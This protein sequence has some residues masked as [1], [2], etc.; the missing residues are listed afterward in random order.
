MLVDLPPARTVRFQILARISFDLW[1]A[2]LTA[3]D[4]IPVGFQTACQLRLIDGRSV[5]LSFVKLSRLERTGLAL[6]RLR[7]IEDDAMRMQLRGGV[8]IY[9]TGT[10]VFEFG[11]HPFTRCFRS[12]IASH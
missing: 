7:N 1:R 10:I 6:F 3:F 9:R 5:L 4:F 8:A 11:D 2:I 12:T